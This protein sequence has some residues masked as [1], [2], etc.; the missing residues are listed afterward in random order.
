MGTGRKYK[1]FIP[2][3]LGYGERGKGEDIG[4]NALLTFEVELLEIIEKPL[5]PP[6]PPVQKKTDGPKLRI[7]PPSEVKKD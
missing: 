7:P 3:K 1:L 5:G 6:A 4:P 2:S